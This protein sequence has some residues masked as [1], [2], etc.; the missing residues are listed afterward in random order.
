MMAD[1]AK[2]KARGNYCLAGGPNMT[3]CKNDSLTPGISMHYFPKDEPLRKKW[4]RFVRVHRKD[5]VPS[6]SATLCSV[7]FDEKC[8]VSKPVPSTSAETGKAL[9][10]KR[11][12]IKGSVPT[13]SPITSRK[14]RRVSKNTIRN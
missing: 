4:T 11:Y 10:P 13:S 5:F 8:F 1:I 7:H 6:K 2:K 3:N 9:Q 12:V 14:C